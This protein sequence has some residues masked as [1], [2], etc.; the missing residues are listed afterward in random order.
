MMNTTEN[1]KKIHA[2]IFS[3]FGGP[4][5]AAEWMGW[6][7]IFHCEINKFSQNILKYY[8]PNAISY[9][10]ITQT[11]FTI[12]RGTIDVLTGGFPCQPFSN[13]GKR[14]GAND[15]RYLW[16]E[17]LRAAREIEPPFLI[18]ENV[19]GI[20]SMVFNSKVI[21]VETEVLI[22]GEKIHRT[23]EAESIILRICEDLEKIGYEVQPIIVP[24][25]GVGA[26]HR[27]D[28][29]WFI[30]F[31]SNYY[32]NKKKINLGGKDRQR[33]KKP[34]KKGVFQE[35]YN[36]CIGFCDIRTEEKI[37]TDTD[38]SNEWSLCGYESCEWGENKK[39]S[40]SSNNGGDG[41]FANTNSFGFGNENDRIRK[42]RL[43]NKTSKDNYWRNFP[44]ES[45]VCGRNDGFSTKL[46][47]ITVS[48]RKG[49]R[50]LTDQQ[51]LGR[52]RSESIRG[53]GNAIVPQVIYEFYQAIEIFK[54]SL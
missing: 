20:T 46:D 35:S 36:K 17:M 9:E 1:I 27:R 42:S 34:Y 50:A 33:S 49:T 2:S 48:A 47:R 53:F 39:H 11:D 16:P 22:E 5:L 12:H 3:G 45:P 23:L 14:E 30:A 18:G 4:D 43:F 8:W 6:Q 10:D 24:A 38:C 44:T 19:T 51:A 37:I 52:W 29:V 54:K 40:K 32:A 21:E 7:N 26:P 25:C 28:R 41:S 31:N 13:A 15:N